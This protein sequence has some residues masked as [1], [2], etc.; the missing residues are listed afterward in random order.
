[1]EAVELKQP[2]LSKVEFLNYGL[3][4][5][6]RLKLETVGDGGVYSAATPNS[7]LQLL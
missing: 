2:E 3:N 5:S 6:P 7:P 1:M 4:F